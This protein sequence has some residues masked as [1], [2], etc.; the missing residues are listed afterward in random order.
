MKAL[1]KFVIL[2]P[3]IASALIS[4]NTMAYETGE[5]IVRAGT[6]SV[7]PN[8]DSGALALN[9]TNLENLGLGLP[10]SKAEVGDNVQLGL[11]I[12]YILNPNW[13]VELLA[14][15]PFSHDINVAGLGVKAGSTKQLPPTL[16]FQY[17]P[18][19]N[20]AKIQPY[21]GLGINYTLFFSEDVDGELDAALAG[22]GATSGAGLDLKNSWGLSA[23]IGLDY[24]INENWLVNASVWYTDIDTK[25]TFTVPG[26]GKIT[27][28]VEI[29][30]LVYM[31]SLGY[32]F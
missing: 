29:D 19:G 14:A 20:N 26:L 13:G 28:N 18:M 17:Y 9:G 5:W 15:T 23:E 7:Q 24:E 22:L 30:P 12:T 3:I 16:I 1:G 25:A 8:D 21:L 32:K 31:L 10:S 6:A 27:T 2:A 11:T 4:T